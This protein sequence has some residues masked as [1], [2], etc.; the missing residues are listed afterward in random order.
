[1]K[2]ILLLF[3]VLFVVSI[4]DVSAKRVRYFFKSIYGYTNKS[5]KLQNPQFGTYI[6]ELDTDWETLTFKMKGNGSAKW[7]TSKYT[8]VDT[9]LG[10]SIDG[11][12]EVA[13]YSLTNG[14][15]LLVERNRSTKQSTIKIEG[16]KSNI[17]F[18]TPYKTE[19][20]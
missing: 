11:R 3:L 18:G 9:D 2:K 6:L 5:S 1:M 19:N 4:N 17:Y 20:Y 10:E 16:G 7:Q 8:I 14:M 13:S 15:T 12:K